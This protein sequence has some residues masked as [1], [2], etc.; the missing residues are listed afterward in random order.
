VTEDS[1]G[2]NNRLTES[3]GSE[4]NKR[5][6][7]LHLDDED[8]WGAFLD[9]NGEDFEFGTSHH[10][11]HIN[12]DDDLFLASEL[13]DDLDEDDLFDDHDDDLFD[14]EDDQGDQAQDERM[15]GVDV[16]GYPWPEQVG[17]DQGNDWLDEDESADP[18]CDDDLLDFDYD[19]LPFNFHHGR[20]QHD[21]MDHSPVRPFT[22]GDSGGQFGAEGDDDDLFD[23]DEEL[24]EDDSHMEH[25]PPAQVGHPDRHTSPQMDND[26]SP[27][28]PNSNHT[29]AHNTL[30]DQVAIG[31]DPEPRDTTRDDQ[32]LDDDDDDLFDDDDEDHSAHIPIPGSNPLLDYRDQS[33]QLSN[34]PQFSHEPSDPTCQFIHDIKSDLPD[35]DRAGDADNTDHGEEDFFDEDHMTYHPPSFTHTPQVQHISPLIRLEGYQYI[36]PRSPQFSLGQAGA[37]ICDDELFDLFESDDDLESEVGVYT[38]DQYLTNDAESSTLSTLDS[39]RPSS[40]R[41][42]LFD[43]IYRIPS[44]PSID[45]VHYGGDPKD[46]QFMFDEDE[47][48]A[49]STSVRADGFTSRDGAGLEPTNFFLDF[50]DL[51]GQD[52]GHVGSGALDLR[53]PENTEM[54]NPTSE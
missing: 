46:D 18:A 16:V 48:D 32:F 45:M 40:P 31:V 27:L 14:S 49:T 39:M 25:H 21:Q 44:L 20:Q 7:G 50:E 47:E 9:D 22:Y 15:E 5:M 42:D 34:P 24:F 17:Y 36:L 12:Y 41:S 35:G 6:S 11:Q 10:I 2:M 8:R 1:N 53:P 33:S 38:A 37:M 54:V 51:E 3:Q 23:D 29:Y 28:N 26:L 30:G 43:P 19:D 13:E 52:R 4:L